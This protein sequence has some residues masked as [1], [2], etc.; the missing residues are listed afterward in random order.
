MKTYGES[1]AVAWN[2][3]QSYQILLET[4]RPKFHFFPFEDWMLSNW[5][6]AYFSFQKFLRFY[7]K[8]PAT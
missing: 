6:D 7:E 1:L 3:L 5:F 4:N 8:L 2:A